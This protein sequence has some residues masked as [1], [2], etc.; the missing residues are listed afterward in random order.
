MRKA[1]KRF[2]SVPRS[3]TEFDTYAMSRGAIVTAIVW[4]G[5]LGFMFFQE[6]PIAMTPSLSSTMMAFNYMA[7]VG[8]SFALWIC[9]TLVGAAIGSVLSLWIVFFI[10][11]G[12]TIHAY[13][14]RS[15]ID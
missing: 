4:G 8:M 9:L 11:L 14:R 1:L 3:F 12:R 7:M 5:W 15:K 2:F 10:F 6:P 13:F